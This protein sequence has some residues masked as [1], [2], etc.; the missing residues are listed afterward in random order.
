MAYTPVPYN[1][2]YGMQSLDWGNWNYS[3]TP[4]PLGNTMDS[5]GVPGFAIP[6][7]YMQ[8]NQALTPQTSWQ[9]FS[10]GVKDFMGSDF[11]KGALGSTNQKTGVTTQGWASPLLSAVGGLTQSWLG[12]QELD[13]K[14]QQMAEGIRQFDKNWAA[15]AA[16]YNASIEDRQRARLGANPNGYQSVGDYM[17]QNRIA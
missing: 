12:M 11:M 5:M 6:T 1:Q 15:Q 7:Q 16:N 14:K 10:T 4:A 2:N 9:S 13:L 8:Q 3:P 17:A